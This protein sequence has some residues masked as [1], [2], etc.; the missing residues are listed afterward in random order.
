MREGK[1]DRLE[2]EGGSTGSH[3]LG[4]F[5]A[6]R[7]CWGCG[8]VDLLPSSL[9]SRGSIFL[10]SWCSSDLVY[11]MSWVSVGIIPTTGID[12]CIYTCV[13]SVAVLNGV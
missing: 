5:Q 11:G 7:S 8:E 13:Y 6:K 10:Q 1:Q 4:Q 12:D 2:W 3:Y 9:L